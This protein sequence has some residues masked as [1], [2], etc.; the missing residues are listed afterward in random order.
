M[1]DFRAHAAD[2]YLT[3]RDA[4][5]RAARKQ[6]PRKIGVSPYLAVAGAVALGLGLSGYPSSGI[7]ASPFSGAPALRVAAP[8][9]APSGV[10]RAA[11]AVFDAAA[12]LTATPGLSVSRAYGADDE[13]CVR[14]GGKVLCR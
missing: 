13:D 12:P 1:D 9:K 10:D 8:A 4:P 3:W 6:P 11:L 7:N 2:R 14:A 5:A